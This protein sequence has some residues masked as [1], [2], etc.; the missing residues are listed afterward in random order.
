MGWEQ[1]SHSLF[2]LDLPAQVCLSPGHSSALLLCSA[3]RATAFGHQ[4]SG[5][6]TGHCSA[7]AQGQ[8]EDPKAQQEAD[9]TQ[10]MT[11]EKANLARCHT[12]AYHNG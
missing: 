10:D 8:A 6:G 5:A 11:G 1:Q 3:R 12:T 2:S 7:V 9:T 4:M